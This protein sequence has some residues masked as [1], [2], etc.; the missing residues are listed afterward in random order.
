MYV[1]IFFRSE[2]GFQAALNSQSWL[3]E[4]SNI[5]LGGKKKKCWRSKL[6]AFILINFIQTVNLW[7]AIR[8]HKILTI[9]NEKLYFHLFHNFPIKI[10]FDANFIKR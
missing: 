10:E 6:I 5:I 9:M 2:F 8:K 1:Q 3:K 7:T 4:H